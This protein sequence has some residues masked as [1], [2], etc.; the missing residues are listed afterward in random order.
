MDAHPAPHAFPRFSGEAGDWFPRSFT[1]TK[2][3][4]EVETTPR[5]L[6]LPSTRLPPP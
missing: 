2:P 4:K 3:L 6:S 1:M 5:L